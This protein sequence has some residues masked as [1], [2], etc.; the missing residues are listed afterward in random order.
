M[1]PLNKFP[2]HFFDKYTEKPV[3]LLPY[4]SRMEVLA[5]K[6]IGVIKQ[7]LNKYDV[8]IR[9]IGSVAYKIPT[10]DVEIAIYVK[11]ND[12]DGV[13][14]SLRREFGIPIQIEKEF[15]RYSIP[16]EEYEFDIHVYTGYEGIVSK[17]LT[18]FMLNNPKLINDY[19]RIK[20]QYSFS[21]REYQYQ[22]SKF[23]SEVIKKIP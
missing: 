15:S 4:S 8:E 3:S 21:K 2:R 14:N 9:T 16:G 7:L 18:E 12:W 23:L 17:K 11:G 22:K 20:S 13:N 10:T 19:Q 6:Y 1:K 5:N